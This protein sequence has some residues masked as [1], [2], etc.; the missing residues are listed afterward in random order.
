MEGERGVEI[1]GIEAYERPVSIETK[2]EAAEALDRF[3]IPEDAYDL[4]WKDQ[5]R[6]KGYITAYTEM[7]AARL[8]GQYGIAPGVE[9][10]PEGQA[11][12]ALPPA[13][14]PTGE[15]SSL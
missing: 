6:Y 12:T 10:L 9:I 8:N 2:E 4:A 11:K 7:I 5:E 14:N 13:T 1:C 15:D 3:M